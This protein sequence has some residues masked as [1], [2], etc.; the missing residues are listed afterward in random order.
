MNYNNNAAPPPLNIQ[1]SGLFGNNSAPLPSGNAPPPSNGH[2]PP[3]SGFG[4][5]PFGGLVYQPSFLQN[6]PRLAPQPNSAMNNPQQFMRVSFPGSSQS[7]YPDCNN[8]SARE[9]FVDENNYTSQKIK[10]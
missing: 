1:Q 8:F 4:Q 5:S 9:L 3:P 10:N 2:A 7:M 6:D